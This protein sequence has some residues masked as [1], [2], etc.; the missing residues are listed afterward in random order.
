MPYS[1]LSTQF[2]TI[3]DSF[4]VTQGAQSFLGYNFTRFHYLKDDYG[5]YET[6]LEHSGFNRDFTLIFIDD[7]GKYNFVN[8]YEVHELASVK[9]MYGV[10]E[11]HIFLDYLRDDSKFKT[12]NISSEL[13]KIKAIADSLTK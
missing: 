5:T 2:K 13:S 7:T 1:E 9:D 8:E 11:K 12:Q 4:R 10:S 3:T 6:S